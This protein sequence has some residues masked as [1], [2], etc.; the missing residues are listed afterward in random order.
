MWFGEDEEENHSQQAVIGQSRLNWT[1]AVTSTSLAGIFEKQNS[2][3]AFLH[4]PA[5]V[6]AILE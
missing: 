5:P 1:L 3:A 6:Q 2:L 4:N